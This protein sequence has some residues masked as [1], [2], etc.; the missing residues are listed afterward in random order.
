MT[1]QR[2]ENY[3]AALAIIED[4]GPSKLHAAERDT[5]LECAE[6]LLLSDD[7]MLVQ[8]QRQEAL[9]LLARLV[10]SGR[11]LEL[12]ARR[13]GDHISACGP[14]ALLAA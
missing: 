10:E 13:L 1:P 2:H 6:D 3:R 4:V 11:W 9:E 8:S 7:A 14:G 5:L 12:T